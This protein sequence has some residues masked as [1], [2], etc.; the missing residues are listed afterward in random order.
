MCVLAC[1]KVVGEC[2]AREHTQTDT[3]RCHSFLLME[4]IRNES[5]SSDK[6]GTNQILVVEVIRRMATN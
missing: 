6:E 4:G 3:H 2:S 5:D 1:D